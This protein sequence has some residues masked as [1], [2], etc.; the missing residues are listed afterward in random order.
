MTAPDDALPIEVAAEILPGKVD[1]SATARFANINRAEQYAR[2]LADTGDYS[3]GGVW[4]TD[5]NDKR[6]RVDEVVTHAPEF[7]TGNRVVIGNGRKIYEVDRRGLDHADGRICVM[8]EQTG[9]VRLVH[10][11]QLKKL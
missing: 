7:R 5:S 8:S 10:P 9:R 3:A 2:I 11:D 1:P 4:L 6:W